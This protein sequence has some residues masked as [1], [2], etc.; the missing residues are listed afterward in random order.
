MDPLWLSPSLH[1]SLQSP[2]F[3]LETPRARVP[4]FLSDRFIPRQLNFD[5][6]LFRHIQQKSTSKADAL[7]TPNV[8]ES[9]RRKNSIEK[10]QTVLKKNLSTEPENSKIRSYA[11]KR[12]KRQDFVFDDE[13][14]S[15]VAEHVRTINKQPYKILEA[16]K[17]KDDFYYNILDWNKD[18]L[19]AVS[20]NN[21]VYMWT[22]RNNEAEKLIEGKVSSIKFC[23]KGVAIGD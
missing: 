7:S 14:H 15:E 10:Y 6:F 5:T 20:L 22:G 2:S 3:S 16:P 4:L 9:L 21:I 13:N 23:H 19:I 17:L 18:D 8:N 1:P 11:E 12:S